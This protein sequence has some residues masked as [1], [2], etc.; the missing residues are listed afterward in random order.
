MTSLPNVG[1][2]ATTATA[3]ALTASETSRTSFTTRCSTGG[4][5]ETFLTCT[6]AAASTLSTGRR[7]REPPLKRSRQ[8]STASQSSWTDLSMP[9][10]PTHRSSSFATPSR[11]PRGTSL[12][13]SPRDSKR[14]S[15]TPR[16]ESAINTASP[17]RVSSI[18]SVDPAGS[19]A[20]WDWDEGLPGRRAR[21]ALT[22]VTA[23]ASRWTDHQDSQTGPPQRDC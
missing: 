16:V 11:L 2:P 19:P 6:E 5:P 23:Q 8:T 4:S 7:Q 21:V 1:P 9:L 12:R 20:T 3:P 10:R 15:S 22:D 18:L 14:L 13:L 17:Q